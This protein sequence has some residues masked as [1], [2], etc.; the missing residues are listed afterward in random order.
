MATEPPEIERVAQALNHS[1][2]AELLSKLD[3]RV[4]CPSE[5][6]EEVDAAVPVVAYHVQC[7][8]RWRLL[9]LVRTDIT[10]ARGAIKHYYTATGRAQIVWTDESAGARQ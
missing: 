9:R 3:G 10:D 7:L 8:L 2:R 1:L 4:A 6:A 5:L